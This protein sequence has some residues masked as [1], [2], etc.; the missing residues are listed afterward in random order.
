[1]AT[2]R[3]RGSKALLFGWGGTAPSRAEVRHP[4]DDGEVIAAVRERPKRGVVARGLGRA[5]GDAA[6]NSG[7]LVLE[8]TALSGVRHLDVERARATVAA[9]T[10]LDDLMRWLLP[11]GFF[12]VTPGTRS[13]TV[14]G[15]I[16]S[17]IHG[18]GHHADGTFGSNVRALSLVDG[19]GTLRRLTPEDTPEEF[20]ATTGGMGLTGVI[21]EAEI[22]LI[23]VETSVIRADTERASD[24]DD[25]M[26]RLDAH[27]DEYRYS[28]AWIDCLATGRSTGRG[29][30]DRGDHATL[31]DLKPARRGN[32]RAFS[33]HPIISAPPIF[34]SGLV[35]RWTVRAFNELWFRKSPKRSEGHLVDIGWFFHPLDLITGWNRLYGPRGFV[36]Y[37]FVVPFGQEH[38]VQTAVE[39]LS[40]AGTPSLLAVLKRF[41]P[42]NPGPLS[43]PQPGWT[44]ALDIPVGDPTLPNLL[45][46][47]DDLVLDAG[48]RVY[49]AKD[50]RVRPGH[51][52]AM[53]PRLA[54]WRE[55][56][57]RLDPDGVLRS[58]LARRLGL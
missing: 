46:G 43:F 36:Q 39:R 50:A 38:A 15:A 11:E 40:L 29:I 51:L 23:P 37:Q 7:G 12:V 30:I 20:W 57:N 41:G 54:E 9:G 31:E 28:V 45:D 25:L 21:T 16:A 56:R 4:F 32:P 3:R 22:D 44:L 58:D 55:V 53:Y 27:D 19:T 8:A 42:A 52:A 14:G 49:L 2:D 1:M 24:L 34:P 35:N 10:S 47:L 18:K 33:P 5:Y 26:A 6:Q 17:D 48:G 13:V